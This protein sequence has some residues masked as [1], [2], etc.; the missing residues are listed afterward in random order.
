L[1]TEIVRRSVTASAA[2]IQASPI[3]RLTSDP[4]SLGLA[5]SPLV[6]SM[7]TDTSLSVTPV[8]TAA[9]RCGDL[10]APEQVFQRAAELF[11][12]DADVTLEQIDAL[13][14]HY[15]PSSANVYA[16][17]LLYAM[18][19]LYQESAPEFLRFCRLPPPAAFM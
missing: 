8:L 7:Y 2:S 1:L 13:V 12:D 4:L 5:A 3:I 19:H 15:Y 14:R 17:T 10:P 16:T 18:W 9:I 11:N 6:R